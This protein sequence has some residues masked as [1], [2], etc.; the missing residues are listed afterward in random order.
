MKKVIYTLFAIAL[1]ACTAENIPEKPTTP[2]P[3]TEKVSINVRLAEP[4]SKALINDSGSGAASFSWENGDQIGVVVN[5]KYYCFTLEGKSGEDTG[6]FTAELPGGST[7]DDGAQIA[8]PYIADDYNESSHTFSLTYPTEY[9]STKAGDFRHRWAGTLV[10]DGSNNFQANLAHQ[11]AIL[12]ITYANVPADATAIKITADKN[13]AGSSKTITTNFSWHASTLDFYFPVP[14]ET[15]TSFTIELYNG[16]DAIDGTQ[17]T[18]ANTSMVLETGKIYRTPT[19]SLGPKKILVAYFSFTNTTKGIADS[20]A[21]I[22]GADTYQIT[23]TEAYASDNNNYYDSSTR[24]YQEQYGPASARPSINTTLTSTDYDIVLLG[25]PIWYGKVPRVIL[26]FLDAYDFSGKTVIPFCTSGSSGISA[27]Q[28]ELQSTYSSINWKSGSRLNGYTND[29][30][31]TWLT[32]LGIKNTPFKLTIGGTDFAAELA[33]NATAQAFNA[34]LPITLN[35]T[36]LNGNEKYKYLDAT[37]PT[38]AACPGTIH[39]GDILLYS[40]NCVVVFYKTFSTSYSYTK[41][42]RMADSTGLEEAVGAVSI[43]IQFSH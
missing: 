24:A 42:G 31:K 12:R 21:D 36:E 29:Q 2:E 23:P 34:L 10:K 7:I 30:L 37:L 27:A 4:A 41:I 19:I 3:T 15:Y 26:S 13:L 33:N 28:T 39:A 8:Y 35:M 32:G 22:L 16:A 9:T 5:N 11:T 38:N 18:L 17:R 14:A 43:S 6:T 40:N 25:F 1:A 20:I